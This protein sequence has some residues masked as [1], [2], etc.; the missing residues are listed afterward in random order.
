M[1]KEI[2]PMFATRQADQY[3]PSTADASYP[4]VREY[5]GPYGVGCRP[6][7]GGRRL[8]EAPNGIVDK[9]RTHE[10]FIRETE[11]VHDYLVRNAVRLTRQRADA[12]DLVQETLLKAYVSFDSYREGTH[13]ISWLSKIMSNT[14]ID[15][16]RSSQR[17]PA[18]HLIA[19]LSEARLGFDASHTRAGWVASAESQ[20]LRSIPGDVELALRGLPDELR[21]IVYYACIA[22]YRNTEIATLLDIPVGTVGSRLHRGKALLRE[23]LAVPGG[24]RPLPRQ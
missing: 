22:G 23:A 12:E 1:I 10:R 20:A 6:L 4:P 18:E 13:L 16:H 15:K 24:D 11:P 21:A 17:R 2:D 5:G 7:N 19:E 3:E 14:W 8:T 9:R